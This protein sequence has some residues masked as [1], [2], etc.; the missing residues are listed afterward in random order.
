TSGPARGAGV[1]VGRTLRGH[2]AEAGAR[3]GVG[4]LPATGDVVGEAVPAVRARAGHRCS[5]DGF[6]RDH[7]GSSPQP[8]TGSVLFAAR[9]SIPAWTAVST[10]SYTDRTESLVVGPGGRRS[11]P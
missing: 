3:T 11:P 8:K 10:C 2:P 9:A 1:T 4:A 6:E 5:A 7:G